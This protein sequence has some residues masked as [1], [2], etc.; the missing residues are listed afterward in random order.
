MLHPVHLLHGKSLG[1]DRYGERTVKGYTW[2]GHYIKG[3]G[4]VVGKIRK[5]S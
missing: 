2:V 5:V 4:D 3:D 1:M